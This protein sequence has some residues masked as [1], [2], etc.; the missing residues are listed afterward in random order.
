[1]STTRISRHV[2]A[3]RASVYRALLDAR[4]VQTWMVPDG[5]TSHVHAFEPREGGSFRIS[6]TYDAPTSTGKT[7]A[8][9]DTHHGRFV[10]LVPDEQVVQVVEFETDDPAMRGEMTITYTLT[11][12]DGGTDIHAVH[13]GLPRGVSPA[14][15]ELGWQMSLGKLAALVEGSS[16]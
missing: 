6:L 1:M 11:N 13:E 4:A 7:T 10:K 5:M 12:A 8:H 15:N 9:T 14:D 2:N 3:P 16:P